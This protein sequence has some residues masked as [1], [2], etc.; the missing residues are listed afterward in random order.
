MDT[1]E[2]LLRV[3]QLG[4]LPSDDEDWTDD[5]ILQEAWQALLDRFAQPVSAIRNG[6][7]L[8][9][10]QLSTTPNV[11][12]YRIPPR[13]V[14][15]GLEKLEMSSDNGASWWK[16]VALTES[17]ATDYTS[18]NTNQP[19]W[20][21]YESDGVILYPTPS[22]ANFLLRFS[23]YL[24]PNQLIPVVT[25]GTV[26]NV[27][28]QEI[29]VVGDPTTLLADT[30]TIDV[31]NTSGWNEVAAVSMPYSSVGGVGFGLFQITV[32]PGTDLSRVIVGQVVR[33]PD[34]TDQ[35]PL[36]VE[37]H[38]ALVAY[39]AAVIL[40]AKGDSD[41]ASQCSSKAESAIKRIVDACIPRTKSQLPNFM[42]RSTFLRRRLGGTGRG[43][44]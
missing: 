43:W 1:T 42:T 2:F 17:Q 44:R 16:L 38:S 41:K 29:I 3:R 39:T 7:W 24:R 11:A 20:F 14:V 6:S 28:A 25:E 23:Y 33:V 10:I 37:L 31:I 8:H 27:T 15:Q 21:S 18:N 22:S 5:Q 40:V 35:I 9:R 26:F 19:G 32:P 34:T 30:T 12:F 13:A 4:Q 36:P